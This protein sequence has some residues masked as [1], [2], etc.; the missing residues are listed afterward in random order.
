LYKLYLYK[1]GLYAIGYRKN[2]VGLSQLISTHLL[3]IPLYAIYF[4]AFIFYKSYTYIILWG[5]KS[6][7]YLFHRWLGGKVQSNP[8]V[9]KFVYEICLKVYHQ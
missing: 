4:I 6:V 8:I 7:L 5:N 2:N 9:L 1:L 3:L